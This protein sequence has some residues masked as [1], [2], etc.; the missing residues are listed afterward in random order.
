MIEQEQALERQ[1][2]E[3]DDQVERAMRSQL[4]KEKQAQ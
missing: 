4:D 1:R 3:M 2:R